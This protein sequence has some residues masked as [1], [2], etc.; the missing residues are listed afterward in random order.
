MQHYLVAHV[1]AWRVEHFRRLPDGSWRVTVHGPD[2]A[3]DLD[4]VGV[5]VSVAAVY[6]GLDTVGGAARDAV[7]RGRG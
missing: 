1:E 4:A 5:T 7:F 6:A 2:D 3:I